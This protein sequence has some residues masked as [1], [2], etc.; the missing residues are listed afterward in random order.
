MSERSNLALPQALEVVGMPV[1]AR[2]GKN[3]VSLG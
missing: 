2:F 3:L 1:A